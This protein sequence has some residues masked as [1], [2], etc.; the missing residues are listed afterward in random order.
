MET[1]KRFGR[2]MHATK[3]S[4][5]T[6]RSMEKA[7]SCGLMDPLMKVISLRIISTA[8]ESILGLMEDATMASGLRIRW[9]DMVCLLGVMAGSTKD[10]TLTTRRK[11][12]ECSHGLMDEST[13]EAGRM[14]SSM[15][16]AL[17]TL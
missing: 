13:M 10:S 17:I 4:I 8:Q 3:V 16:R 14:V 15:E 9:M 5:K 12:R 7:N 2:T 11:A 1:V 6:E